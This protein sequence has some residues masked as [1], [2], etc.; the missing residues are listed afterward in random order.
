MAS[1]KVV[2]A[3]VAHAEGAAGILEVGPG[4]GVLT[5]PLTAIAQR[6][7]TI[8]LDTAI[9]PVLTE[10]APLA[11]IIQADALKVDLTQIFESLPTPRVLVSNMPYNI[12]GPLLTLFAEHRSL[13]VRSILMMQR[14]V[15]ERILSPAGKRERGSLSVYLEA[16]FKIEKVCSVPPGA[17]LPPPKVDSVVLIFTPLPLRPIEARLFPIARKGFTQPRKTLANNLLG[18]HG[19]DK[20]DVMQHLA[21]CELEG[22]VRPHQLL[23]SEWEKLAALD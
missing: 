7:V 1:T 19:W 11:Q 9:L 20:E 10:L 14:E 6:V 16:Q 2:E 4:P 8:E 18:Y 21:T 15:A 5:R 3:I 12:T 13:Y 17:F 23:L 22:N